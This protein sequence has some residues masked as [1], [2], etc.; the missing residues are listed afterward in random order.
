MNISSLIDGGDIKIK[1][2]KKKSYSKS[3]I[4]KNYKLFLNKGKGISNDI[5]VNIIKK[6]MKKSKDNSRDIKVVPDDSKSSLKNRG[7]SI[8]PKKVSFSPK[9]K[10]RNIASNVSFSSKKKKRFS[11]K[12]NE[13]NPKKRVLNKKHTKSRRISFKCYSN[14]NHKSLDKTINDA[15]KLSENKIRENLLKNGISIKS[16]NKKLLKDLY[17]FSNMGGI[18]VNRE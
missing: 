12:R 14:N 2:N 15:N 3:P 7:K 10:Q 5:K 9:I 13:K 8:T 6:D 1:R 18:T 11:R 17:V 16:N 4:S